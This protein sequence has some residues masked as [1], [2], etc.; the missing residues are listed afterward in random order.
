[1]SKEAPVTFEEIVRIVTSWLANL[2][3][4]S[5]AIVVGVAAIR[6]LLTFLAAIGGL[7][8]RRGAVTSGNEIPKEEIRLSLARSLALALEFEVGAD[9]LRT[10]VTPSWNDIVLLGAIIL[11]RTVL[12]YFLQR[13]LDA[14]TKRAAGMLAT[15]PVRDQVARDGN[16]RTVPAA[17]VS[18]AAPRG[19]VG[20]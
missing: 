3:D 6:G 7:V 12:N 15:E 9:I 18:E 13:E 11:L 20:G 10:V 2:A 1:V 4:L 5:G 16:L 19:R 8:L 14:A 17:A